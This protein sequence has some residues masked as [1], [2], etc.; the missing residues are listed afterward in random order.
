MKI[1]GFRHQFGLKTVYF[2]EVG[3]NKRSDLTNKLIW[4]YIHELTPQ[5][6]RDHST[7]LI[8]IRSQ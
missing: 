8:I 6:Q 4:Y 7:K 1:E 5:L 2:V 3:I